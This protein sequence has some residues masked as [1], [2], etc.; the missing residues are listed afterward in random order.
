MPLPA[1]TAAQRAEAFAKV[2][3]AL[4]FVLDDVGVSADVQAVIYH[5]GFTTLRRFVGLEDAKSEVRAVLAEQFGLVSSEGLEQRVHVADVL[6]AW[7]SAKEQLGR[8]N[9]IRAEQRA[10]RVSRPVANTEHKAMR[11]AF[12]RIHGELPNREVPGKYFLG[13]KLE[14]VEENDPRP[15][16]LQD[17]TSREDG[18]MD[19]LSA[20][21]N[22]RGQVHVKKGAAQSLKLPQNGEELRMR[23]RVLGNAWVFCHMKHSSRAWL[24]GLFSRGLDASVRLRSRRQSGG[25]ARE[26]FKRPGDLPSALGTCVVIRVRTSKESVRAR[27]DGESL[28]Q[29][30]KDVARDTELKEIHFVTPWV[31]LTKRK[32]N[33]WESPSK[34]QKG[35]GKGGSGKFGGAFQSKGGSDNWV[36]TKGGKGDKGGKGKKGKGKGKGPRTSFATPD[37]R[38]ICFSYN[39]QGQ[40]CDGSCGRVHCCQICF[41][42]EH[43]KY[44][45]PQSTQGHL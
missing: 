15:E 45:C 34:F 37:G 4:A 39:N 41:S 32:G 20:E 24:A 10:S 36:A 43:G 9:E 16:S 35:N 11:Q 8:E 26:G 6:A 42:V 25:I 33:P 19:Y 28:K 7:E 12:E 27:T 18:E 14:Q 3:P 13:I 23:H 22:D 29:A 2:E 5:K 21:I 31:L 1:L 40:E 30:L 38:Q 44:A 17:V